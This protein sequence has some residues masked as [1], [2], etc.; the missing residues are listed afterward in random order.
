[1]R[2]RTESKVI[3]FLL[4]ITVFNGWSW[5]VLKD[6]IRVYLQ[7]ENAGCTYETR[8][9]CGPFFSF[10]VHPLLNGITCF[11]Q[12]GAV[13]LIGVCFIWLAYQLLFYPDPFRDHGQAKPV[14][15]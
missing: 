3:G 7:A 13:V 1:M 14:T 6:P 8:S 11:S 2:T 5:S 15:D 4:V 9:I 10:N 12:I